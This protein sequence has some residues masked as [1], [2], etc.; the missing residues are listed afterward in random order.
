ML[1]SLWKDKVETRE[2]SKGNIVRT[3]NLLKMECLL[4]SNLQTDSNEAFWGPLAGRLRFLIYCVGLASRSIFFTQNQ[5]NTKE[6]MDSYSTILT[7][8]TLILISQQFYDDHFTKKQTGLQ[9]LNDL[10]RV[11]KY[12]YS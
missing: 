11:Y 1:K 7:Y 10:V 2:G 3:E 4:P 12:L 6:Y 9:S 8:N 5:C